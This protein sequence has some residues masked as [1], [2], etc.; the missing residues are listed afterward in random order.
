MLDCW[1]DLPNSCT[2]QPWLSLPVARLQESGRLTWLAA[3]FPGGIC[4]HLATRADPLDAALALRHSALAYW[5][6]RALFAEDATRESRNPSAG[7]GRE[8]ICRGGAGTQ[9]HK[10]CV[11]GK[12]RSGDGAQAVGRG[13]ART[14]QLKLAKGAYGTG[15]SMWAH[16]AIVV[17]D[18]V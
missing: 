4:K 11:D 3:D 14:E 12:V 16:G 9:L 7:G 6:L 18:R 8:L 17:E 13:A 1:W 15:C 5:W 10:R 2:K